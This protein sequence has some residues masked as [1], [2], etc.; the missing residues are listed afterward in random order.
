V[1]VP[2]RDRS[3]TRLTPRL[4][5]LE[6]AALHVGVA[7]GDVVAAL[8]P[9]QLEVV[10]RHFARD[11]HQ[12]VLE[13]GHRAF[14]LGAPRFVVAAHAPEDVELPGGVEARVID[15]DG[16]LAI[17]DV[18][19]LELA[20]AGPEGRAVGRDHWTEIESRLA[21]QRTRLV[22][23]RRRDAQVMIRRE[24]FLDETAEHL[25]VENRPEPGRDVLLRKRL[26]VRTDELLR[27]RR[28]RLDVVRPDSAGRQ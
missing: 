13:R 9:S 8:K 20:E 4:G 11:A 24:R 3:A 10:A 15:I 22:E 26:L 19:R 28:V 2:R 17:G 6:G 16:A 5:Q 23:A 25:I 27:Q 7:P 18:R 21:T 1:R 14:E 12:R